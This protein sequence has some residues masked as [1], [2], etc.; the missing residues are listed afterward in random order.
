MGRRRWGVV[1]GALLAGCGSNGF[2]RLVLNDDA[3]SEPAYSF[4]DANYRLDA[5]E[6]GGQR[7]TVALLDW[8]GEACDAIDGVL[9]ERQIVLTFEADEA[10]PFLA[11]G[12][13]RVR[14]PMYTG[15]ADATDDQGEPANQDGRA[16]LILTAFDPEGGLVEG[17]A[18][19]SLEAAYQL[20]FSARGCE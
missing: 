5:L 8:D 1:V 2:G 6:G 13:T 4:S 3:K 16:T 15:S 19:V 20:F 9:H 14:D 11:T 17:V 7:L 18:D 10:A 12:M